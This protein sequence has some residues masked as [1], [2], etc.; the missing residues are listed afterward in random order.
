MDKNFHIRKTFNSHVWLIGIVLLLG[1]GACQEIDIDGGVIAKP[2]PVESKEIKLIIDAT[3]DFSNYRAH[4]TLDSASIANPLEK[5][6][7]PEDIVSPLIFTDE[8][9]GE[10]MAMIQMDSSESEVIVNAQR[11]TESI[12]FLLP[13]YHSLSQEQRIEFLSNSR[14]LV[15]YTAFE[16]AVEGLLKAKKSV[17]SEEPDFTSLAIALNES[18]V[19]SYLDPE[20]PPGGRKNEVQSEF[21][22]W[23]TRQSDA[24]FVNQVKSYVHVE[25]DPIGPGAGVS[26]L[27]DPRNFYLAPEPIPFSQFSVPDNCYTVRISQSNSE[28]VSRNTL[29][30]AESAVSLVFDALFGSLG[31]SRVDCIAKIAGSLQ[32]GINSIILNT[33]NSD[34]RTE[35]VFIGIIKAVEQAIFTNASDL[36]CAK[37]FTSKSTI[38]KAI[39]KNAIFIGRLIDGL[40]LIESGAEATP[41]VVALIDGVELDEVIQIYE[42]KLKEACIQLGKDGELNQEYSTGDQVLVKVKLNPLSEYSDWEKSGF[43][44]TWNLSPLNGAVSDLSSSTKYPPD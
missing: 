21:S 19:R 14:Q 39:S 7:G 34:N 36:Q 15:E 41:F 38:Y 44:I 1:S 42:G 30:L 6:Y 28:A 32:S 43:K 24:S 12:L 33:V 40:G 29:K 4:T 13:A 35:E 5:L 27:V 2:Q 8:V 37:F 22:S 20:N 18:I 10:V 26:T 11:I 17:Y 9:T 3:L 16:D 25:F 23:V 31:N